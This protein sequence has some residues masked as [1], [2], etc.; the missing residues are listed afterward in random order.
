MHQTELRHLNV[1]VGKGSYPYHPPYDLQQLVSDVEVQTHVSVG[2][3]LRKVKF[4]GLLLVVPRDGVCSLPFVGTV[5]E[6]VV[7]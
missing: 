4:L 1:Q 3:Y 7:A 6:C 2:G 5:P